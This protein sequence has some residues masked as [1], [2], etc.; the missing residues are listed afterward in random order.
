MGERTEDELYR[1]GQEAV[2][3][4]LRHSGASRIVINL[5]FE[6]RRLNMTVTDDGMGF[7]GDVNSTGP[8]GHFGLRGM[9]ERAE[10]ID[11]E[12]RIE[13]SAGTGTTVSVEAPA[14]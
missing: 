12:L 14:K 6:A 2:T 11:A 8:D 10:Q 3:N 13:S 9:R 7:T 4:A 1:I 5:L